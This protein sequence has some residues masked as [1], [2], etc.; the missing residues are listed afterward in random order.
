MISRCLLFCL[1]LGL[2]GCSTKQQISIPTYTLPALPEGAIRTLG[3]TSG[4]LTAPANSGTDT[5]AK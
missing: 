4:G 1:V 5:P 2:F 3:G